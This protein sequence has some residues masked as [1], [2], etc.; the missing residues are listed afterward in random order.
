M[1]ITGG[2]SLLQAAWGGGLLLSKKH[3]VKLQGI[4]K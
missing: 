4:E 1:F 2:F 3:K